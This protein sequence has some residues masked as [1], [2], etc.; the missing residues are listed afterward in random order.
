MS[1]HAF[2]ALDLFFNRHLVIIVVGEDSQG[3]EEELT[4]SV[5]VNIVPTVDTGRQDLVSFCIYGSLQFFIHILR[6]LII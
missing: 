3:G 5:N 4:R 1:G 2:V 6:C